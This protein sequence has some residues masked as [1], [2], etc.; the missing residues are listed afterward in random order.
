MNFGEAI[1][2][3]KAGKKVAR[4]GCLAARMARLPSGHARGR[5]GGRDMKWF[6]LS[7]FLLFSGD[8]AVSGCMPAKS[9][10]H[11]TVMA[12]AE[13]VKAADATCAKVARQR[14]DL[15][16]AKR[17]ATSYAVA[18]DA[19]MLA[20]AWIDAGDAKKATESTQAAFRALADIVE[21]TR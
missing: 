18:R 10:E 1:D 12:L 17:C 7:G 2:A 16:L 11:Q 13:S 14:R 6:I 9:P 3:L 8:V 4:D 15:A 21:A 20:D 5:L 19:L